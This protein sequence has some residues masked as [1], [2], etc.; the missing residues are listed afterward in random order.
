MSQSPN[1]FDLTGKVAIVTGASRGI[2]AAIAAALSGAGA[3]VTLAGRR[4]GALAETAAR[5]PGRTHVAAGFD[6]TDAAAVAAGIA[7]ARAAFGPVSIL[8]NNAG[9]APTA[10]FEK[11]DDALVARILAVDLAALF[12]V[13]RAALPDIKAQGGLGRIIN[14]AST[15]GLKGYAYATAYSAAKHGVVG[16]TRALALEIVRSGVTVNA[17]CPGFTETPLIDDAVARIVEK[18][19]RTAE[20]TRAE[21]ARANPQ[22]RLIQVDEVAAAALWLCSEGARSVTGQAIALAGGEVM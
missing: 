3:H 8:V 11:T 14:V 13:T 16:L 17:L 1:L 19:G 21:L 9:E 4:A 10:P 12:T 7:G 2:G 18:T 6:V 5:C 20:E 15:A 22:G